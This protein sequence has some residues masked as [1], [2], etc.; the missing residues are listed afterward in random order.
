MEIEIDFVKL[1]LRQGGSIM[2]TLPKDAVKYLRLKGTER[3]KVLIDS[4]KKRVV[5]QF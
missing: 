1:Q 5:Y 2:V 3:A 4:E